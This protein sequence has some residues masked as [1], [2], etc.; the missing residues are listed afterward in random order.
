MSQGDYF[1]IR[2][3]FKKVER[4]IK[5]IDWLIKSKDINF[6]MI[7]EEMG[8]VKG[9][10]T[11]LDKSVFDFREIV[12]RN[13]IDYRFHYMDKNMNLISRWDSAPHHPEIKS[14]PYHL[15]TTKGVENSPKMNLIKCLDEISIKII[16]NI[17]K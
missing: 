8:I 4:K 2:S 13:E 6:D 1:L 14:F 16:Q 17:E 12:S 7:S 15:H 5:S 9:K 11:L 3:Y 10:I